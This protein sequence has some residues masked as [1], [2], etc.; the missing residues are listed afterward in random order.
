MYLGQTKLSANMDISPFFGEKG[1]MSYGGMED[2]A[3]YAMSL[4]ALANSGNYYDLHRMVAED[5]RLCPILFRRYAVYTQRGMLSQLTSVRDNLFPYS[6]GVTMEE[7][8]LQE[9]A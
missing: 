1:A 8:L 5:G 4:E 7:I 6:I 3:L 2:P 9:T